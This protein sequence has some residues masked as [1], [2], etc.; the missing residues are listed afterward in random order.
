VD[1]NG[2]EHLRTA[3]GDDWG[4]SLHRALQA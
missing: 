4:A 3:Q 1:T 2:I